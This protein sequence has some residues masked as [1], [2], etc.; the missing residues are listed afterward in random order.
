[1]FS[2]ELCLTLFL[3]GVG[4]RILVLLYLFLFCLQPGQPG[5]P[6][7]VFFIVV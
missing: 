6:F 3:E 5:H 1:M 4:S 2:S 7:D